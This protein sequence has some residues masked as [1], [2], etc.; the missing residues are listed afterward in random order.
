MDQ[1]C[2]VLVNPLYAGNVGSVARVMKNFGFRELV[3]VNPPKETGEMRAMAMH[4]KSDVLDEAKI[5]ESFEGV[6]GYCDFLVATSAVSGGNRNYNRSPM[7]PEDLRPALSVDGKVGLVFGT[8]DQGLSSK[9]IAECDLQVTIPANPK[10]PVLNL[11]QAVAVMLYEVSRQPFRSKTLLK[12]KNQPISGEA[13]N[14]LLSFFDETADKLY[15]KE[16]ERMIIKKTF[17]QVVGRGFISL[18][19]S[20]TLIGFFRNIADRL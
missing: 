17:R 14:T 13:K 19:E 18:R 16:F 3:L 11:A 8:E 12:R 10:Y 7:L 5:F 2:V 9:Q 4:A 6:K 15:E 20:N 1:F